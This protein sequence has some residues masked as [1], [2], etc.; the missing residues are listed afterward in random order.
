MH[1]MPRYQP[2]SITPSPSVRLLFIVFRN[3]SQSTKFSNYLI[4]FVVLLRVLGDCHIGFCGLPLPHSVPPIAHIFNLS[5]SS[6]KLPEQWKTSLITPVAKIE[7]PSNAVIS[8]PFQSHPFSLEHW[9][10]WSQ[11]HFCTLFWFT[12]ISNTILW[13]SLHSALLAQPTSALIQLTHHITETLSFHPY[14][15]LIQTP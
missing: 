1:I 7:H 3:T 2:T 15:H 4:V 10:S 8:D 11:G 9:K 12:R 5:V 13:V 6:G 14:L